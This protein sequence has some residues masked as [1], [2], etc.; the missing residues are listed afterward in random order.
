MT[1]RLCF[2]EFLICVLN[3]CGPSCAFSE[4]LGLVLVP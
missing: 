4:L 3:S 1:T 2:E